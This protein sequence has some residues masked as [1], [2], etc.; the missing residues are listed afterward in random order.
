MTDWNRLPDA[1]GQ[2]GATLVGF[3]DIAGLPEEARRGY[4][5]A[6]SIGVA[7]EKAVVRGIPTGPHP[8]YEREYGCVNARLDGLARFTAAWLRARGADAHAI[9]VASAPYERETCQTALPHKT[10]A[11]L[12]GHGW[13]GKCALLITPDYGSA[14]RFTTVLTNA[15]LAAPA[16]PQQ[17]RCGG[18]TR[19]A[20]ACPG[21][22]IS[23]MAWAE[24]VARDRLVSIAACQ[25]T[26][27]IRA[28]QSGQR[29]GTCGLCIAACPYTMRYVD[30]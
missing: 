12:A 24:G 26:F 14:V 17:S 21:A 23:G 4:R 28:Q 25:D 1:L 19:C 18:C 15:P 9:T 8:D 2:E 3:A 10:A 7:L 29:N 20:D 22:A 6:V 30:P 13:I 16:Q 5:F 27:R 11:R